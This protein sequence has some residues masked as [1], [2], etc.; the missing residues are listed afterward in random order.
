MASDGTIKINTELDSSQAQAAMSKFSGIA[1]KAMSGVKIA[2]GAASA[3]I[4]AMA[5]YSIKVGSD[6]EAGMSQVSAVSGATGEDLEALTEKAK[7]MG[8]KTKF[9][10]TEAAEAMNYMAMAGWKTSDMLNGIEGIMNLAAASGENLGT[11]ADIVTDALTAFGLSAQDSTHFADV[12]A[13]ASSNANTNVG[14]MGETFKYVAPVAGAMGYSVEDCSLAIGLMANSGIK[15]GQAGTVL[16]SMLSRLAK[17]TD[18]VQGA[19]DKLGVSLT[20]SDGS[21]KSLNEVMG[22]MREGFSGLSKAEQTQ[23]ASALAG[24]EAMSGLLA[25][26]RTRK[27]IRKVQQHWRNTQV[28]SM[29]TQ[30]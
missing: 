22:D 12:L 6:F 20:N 14:M 10:A 16:R 26:V 5:G 2:V 1:S 3:A 21:M 17:P 9:S 18:E 13:A 30:P 24:Q 25:I 28:I 8:A 29:H 19:M 23:T 4:T 15:A 27:R 7:E 11:T